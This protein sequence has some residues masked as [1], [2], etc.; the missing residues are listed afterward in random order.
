ME[1]EDNFWHLAL[2]QSPSELGSTLWLELA[3]MRE[4]KWLAQSNLKLEINESA[5]V[6]WDFDIPYC[7]RLTLDQRG[8]TGDVMAPD[9]K[10]MM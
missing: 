7:L 9:G 6:K 5:G 2:V 3:E 1:N 8:I 10:L 4:G